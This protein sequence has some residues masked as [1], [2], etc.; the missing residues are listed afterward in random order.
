[1]A[2]V[3]AGEGRHDEAVTVLHSVMEQAANPDQLRQI[4]AFDLADNLD[5]L[6]RTAEAATARAIAEG[7]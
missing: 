2:A 4:T 6:G 7:A 1:M 3:L 5:K